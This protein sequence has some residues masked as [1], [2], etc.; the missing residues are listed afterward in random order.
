[1]ASKSLRPPVRTVATANKNS[2]RVRNM[3]TVSHSGGVLSLYYTNL[4]RRA[5]VVGKGESKSRTPPETSGRVVGTPPPAAPFRLEGLVLLSG[6]GSALLQVDG[7]TLPFDDEGV[8]V[9]PSP[10]E[11]PRLLPWSS[12]AAHVIEPWSG[13]IA[14]EWRGGSEPHSTREGVGDDGE[15]IDPDATDRSRP[16]TGAG[17]LISLRPISPP[18]GFLFP[19]GDADQ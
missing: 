19:G 15:V 10:E 17:A 5:A 14:P 1:M 8:G 2:T 13:G 4:F 11:Q 7:I 6:E 12:L 18:L 16:H 9:I 3:P